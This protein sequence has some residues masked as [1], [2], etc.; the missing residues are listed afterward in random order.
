VQPY[1]TNGEWSPDEQLIAWDRQL[2]EMGK[3]PQHSLPVLLFAFW[4]EPDESLQNARFG[5][6][7]VQDEKLAEY[8]HWH[9]ELIPEQAQQWGALIS[10]LQPGPAA[11]EWIEDFRFTPHDDAAE[12]LA[13]RGRDLLLPG[14]RA[15]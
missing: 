10:A 14:L 15:D 5:R 3:L 9:A 13:Q 2:E 11:A 8:C 7:I 6:V 4:S 1:R 12:R